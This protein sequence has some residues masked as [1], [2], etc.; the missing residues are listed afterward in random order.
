MSVLTEPKLWLLDKLEKTNINNPKADSGAVL[1]KLY[2]NY[3]E[4]IEQMLIIAIQEM[5]SLFSKETSDSPSGT[6][7]LTNMA[8]K[9]GESLFRYMEREPVSWRE[10]LD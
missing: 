5:Q 9:V 2:Q 7:P 6:S 3:E 10:D 8:R 4:E 1:I